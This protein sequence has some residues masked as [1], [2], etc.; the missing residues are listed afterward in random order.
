MDSRDLSPE[1]LV[2]MRRYVQKQRDYLVRLVTRCQQLEMW[3]NDPLLHSPDMALH[4]HEQLIR[5]CSNAACRHGWVRR[6]RPFSSSDPAIG[7]DGCFPRLVDSRRVPNDVTEFGVGGTTG[8]GPRR[9]RAHP[10]IFM[11]RCRSMLK[12]L[13]R[14][15]YD[16]RRRLVR[17]MAGR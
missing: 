13:W 11:R 12:R 1:Q 17:A 5:A 7:R 16:D 8:L 2:H 3:S 6:S 15:P 14:P 9:Y 10:P 4:W